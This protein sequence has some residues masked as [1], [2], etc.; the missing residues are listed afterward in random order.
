MDIGL[1]FGSFNPIHIGHLI[2]ANHVLNE[3]AVERMWFIVSPLNPFK[4]QQSL[5]DQYERLGLVKEA[6]ANDERILA[7]DVEFQL[8]KPS[9]TYVTLNYLR[10]N[11]AQH[12][13]SLIMGS[14][15]FQ[16]LNKWKNFQEITSKHK[17]VIY[18]RPGFEVTNE[19][20]AEIQ[21][22]NAPLL[23]IS[24]TEIRDLISKG[25]SIRY[26]VPDSA[27]EKIESK[28]FYRK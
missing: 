12:N 18:Q 4:S 16:S 8:P 21:L 22:V 28:G 2:I 23:N 25:K 9:F 11:F 15:S 10:T 7:S 3:S 13:F 26:L 27:R 14:D 20:N 19:M 17:I 5:L 1:F 24:S 6:I